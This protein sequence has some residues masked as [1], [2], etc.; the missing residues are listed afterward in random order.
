MFKSIKYL[1]IVG[2]FFSFFSFSSYAGLCR[3][4]IH[5]LQSSF[6]MLQENVNK[7]MRE[8]AQNISR[9]ITDISQQITNL[10]NQLEQCNRRDRA[11]S[12]RTK[13]GR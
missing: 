7:E 11:R 8:G 6:R 5:C 3:P 4:G 1:L 10:Q 9:Q 13:T 2:L 12:E